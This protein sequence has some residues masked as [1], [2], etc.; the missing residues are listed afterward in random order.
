VRSG[1]KHDAG[2]ASTLAL[3]VNCDLSD[4]GRHR[5]LVGDVIVRIGRLATGPGSA[6]EED[7]TPCSASSLQRFGLTLSFA[8][9]AERPE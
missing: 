1:W 3:N 2:S 7:A 5:T 9:P 8:D 6:P 4:F